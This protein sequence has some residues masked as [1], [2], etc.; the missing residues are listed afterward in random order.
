MFSEYKFNFYWWAI[1]QHSI[2]RLPVTNN[3]VKYAYQTR[4]RIIERGQCCKHS[5]LFDSRLNSQFSYISENSSNKT[6]QFHVL[7]WSIET[8]YRHSPRRQRE[9]IF[10][11]IRTESNKLTFSEGS[12]ALI[13]V[14]IMLAILFCSNTPYTSFIFYIQCLLTRPLCHGWWFFPCFPRSTASGICGIWD[15]C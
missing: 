5:D 6:H 8:V 14:L 7:P 15:R 10:T 2:F 3:I 12:M 11:T 13:F 4:L 1:Y 9:H